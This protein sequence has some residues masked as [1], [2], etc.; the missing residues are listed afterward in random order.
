MP[1]KLKD[2]VLQNALQFVADNH[3]VK[4]VKA[5]EILNPKFRFRKLDFTTTDKNWKVPLQSTGIRRE[6]YKAME[7]R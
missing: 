7:K 4:R 2:K 3:P 5:Q 1:L 6:R